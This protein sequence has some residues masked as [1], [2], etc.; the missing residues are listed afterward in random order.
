MLSALEAIRRVLLRDSSRT[1]VARN[2]ARLCRDSISVRLM[3]GFTILIGIP[4]NPAP[5]PRS[6]TVDTLL[7]MTRRNNRLSRKRLSMTQAGSDEP[8]SLC[9]PCHFLKSDRYFRNRV[10]S[11]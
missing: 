1:T 2:E 3:S 4:G 5:D 8:T 11:R 7:G 10:N 6:A 9:V